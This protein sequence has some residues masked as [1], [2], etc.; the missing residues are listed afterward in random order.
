MPLPKRRTSTRLEVGA[1]DGVAVGVDGEVGFKGVTELVGHG[2]GTVT[3]VLDPA[4]FHA[5]RLRVLVAGADDA[6]QE[7]APA[8]VDLLGLHGVLQSVERDLVRGGVFNGRDVERLVELRGEVVELASFTCAHVVRALL[9]RMRVAALIEHRVRDAPALLLA[10]VEV[11]ELRAAECDGVAE[12]ATGADEA[13][14]GENAVVGRWP[15]V[16]V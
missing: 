8:V 12:R 2:V 1:E 11:T 7:R 13:A 4:V 16:V 3:V 15:L 14:S 9:V 10:G 6:Q 5:E